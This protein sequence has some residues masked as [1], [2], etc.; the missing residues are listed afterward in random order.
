MAD[1]MSIKINVDTINDGDAYF[2]R[3]EID[4][5]TISIQ[6]PFPDLQSAQKLKAEQLATREKLSGALEEQLRHALATWTQHRS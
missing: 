4:A 1:T 5:H 2:V 6:G 3:A